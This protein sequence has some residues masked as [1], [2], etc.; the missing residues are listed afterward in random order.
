MNRCTPGRR[1]VSAVF[2]GVGACVRGVHGCAIARCR[3][4]KT[5][6]YCSSGVRSM[7][8]AFLVEFYPLGHEKESYHRIRRVTIL[9]KPA[10]LSHGMQ[11]VCCDGRA[12]P[13]ASLRLEASY[14]GCAA[15]ADAIS[16]YTTVS[17][18][19]LLLL[20]ACSLYACK[21]HWER[22]LNKSVDQA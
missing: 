18:P 21:G 6:S 12:A 8:S 3:P 5:S 20:H 11:R 4:D 7:R 14:Y 15:S 2:S 17:S 19:P 10:D 13:A 22:T 16:L 9:F 1:S